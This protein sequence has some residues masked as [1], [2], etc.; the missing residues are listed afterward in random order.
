MGVN[1]DLV[2]KSKTSVV[3]AIFPFTTNHYD[4]LFGGVALQWMD[5]IAFITATRYCRQQI[6]TVSSDK[7]DFKKPIPAATFAELR[8]EVVH[9][10]N[11]S[12]KVKVDIYVEKM[13]SDERSLAVSGIFTMVAI[14]KEGKATQIKNNQ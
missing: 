8:G 7:I 6:A 13:Y 10:G 9:V 4:T 5:E 3:K 2:E 11:S 14:D 1:K 12:I